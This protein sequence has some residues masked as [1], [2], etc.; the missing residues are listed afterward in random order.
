MLGC[1]LPSGPGTVPP[2]RWLAAW[3]TSA[4]T[5]ASKSDTLT[6]RPRP[7]RPRSTSAAWIADRGVQPRDHVQQRHADLRG[8]AVPLAR[9]AHQP[10]E[11]LHD[12][13]VPGPRRGLAAALLGSLSGFW[14]GPCPSPAEGGERA[15]D[16]ARVGRSRASSPRPNRDIS[17][18]RKFSI[19]HVGSQRQAPHDVGALVGLQIQRDRALVAVQAQEVGGVVAD[20]GRAPAS[21]VVAGARPLDLDD[22]GPEVGQHH[23][24][25]GSGEDARQVEDAHALERRRVLASSIRAG[26]SDPGRGTMALTG[27]RTAHPW[28]GAA[29][30]TS[31]RMCAVNEESLQRAN[32]SWPPCRPA[33]RSERSWRSRRRRSAGRSG[34]PDPLSAARAV[35][36]LIA[37]R[38]LEPAQ[39]SYRLDRRPAGGSRREGD[40]RAAAE[41]RPPR[42]LGQA[43]GGRR[44][45]GPRR[46]IRRSATRS[47]RS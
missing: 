43:G 16:Q 1:S 15:R 19:T 44:R 23:R 11:R 40:D 30:G 41:A 46:R 22:V 12:D 3:F 32:A 4:A 5:L 8:L 37:R 38:R 45:A 20:E 42:S 17:P 36:A 7:V 18:G 26:Y 21:G 9:D 13:V 10:G 33:R 24:G 27:C 14:S 2:S 6:C 47:L 28:G 29:L 35:R 34:L 31:A 25:Q 39:G